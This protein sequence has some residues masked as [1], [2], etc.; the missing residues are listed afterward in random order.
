MQNINRLTDFEKFMVTKGDGA[1][2]V[3]RLGA[4]DWHMHTEVYGM[5]DQQ[6]HAYN[7]ENS[8]QYSVIICVGK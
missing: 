8:T 7:T 6:R 2:V 5:I 3:G 1:V 4:W